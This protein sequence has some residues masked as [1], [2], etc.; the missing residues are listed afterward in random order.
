MQELR[1]FEVLITAHASLTSMGAVLS[2]ALSAAGL[3]AD[4][5]ALEGLGYFGRLPGDF[6]V[7][8]DWR[9]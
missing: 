9:C 8:H 1:D 7:P 4:V 3:R 2:A 5:E 6:L